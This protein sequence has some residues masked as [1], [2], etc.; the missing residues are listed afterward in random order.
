MYL[1]FSFSQEFNFSASLKQ[2]L[3]CNHTYKV[4]KQRTA[5]K[6]GEIKHHTQQQTNTSRIIQKQ[7]EI[8][9]KKKKILKKTVFI[10]TTTA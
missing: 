5:Q 3:N 10:E 8:E 6:S 1:S 4:H 2:W 9:R 7:E